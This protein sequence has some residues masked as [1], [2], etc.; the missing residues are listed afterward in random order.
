MH[1]EW[2]RI[3]N[4]IKYLMGMFENIHE[5]LIAE[6]QYSY[7]IQNLIIRY[8]NSNFH[9]KITIPAEAPKP[10]RISLAEYKKTGKPSEGWESAKPKKNDDGKKKEPKLNK[11]DQLKQDLLAGMFAQR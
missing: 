1:G 10:V 9:K 2:K 5:I 11:K 4:M 8:K 3:K 7:G 6:Y